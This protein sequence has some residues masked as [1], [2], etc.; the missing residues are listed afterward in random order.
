M[1]RAVGAG[2]RSRAQLSVIVDTPACGRG[3]RYRL[4]KAAVCRYF[5]AGAEFGSRAGM[6]HALVEVGPVTWQ[7]ADDD[8]KV[9]WVCCIRWA[10]GPC[11][12]VRAR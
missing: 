4:R 8:G 7:S 6:P 5:R 10:G 11:D 1:H 9:V 3:R 2:E 12:D